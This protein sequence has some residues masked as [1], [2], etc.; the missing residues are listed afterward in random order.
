MRGG[1]GG[2]CLLALLGRASL[3]SSSQELFALSCRQGLQQTFR[4]WY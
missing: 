4:N 1:A 3:L 2:L